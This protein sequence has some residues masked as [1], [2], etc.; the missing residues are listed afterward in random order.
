MDKLKKFILQICFFFIYS[1]AIYPE[2][3]KES[4]T[5]EILCFNNIANIL[6]QLNSNDIISGFQNI[7]EKNNLDNIVILNNNNPR[8]FDSINSIYKFFK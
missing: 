3:I 1:N 2:I 6:L 8:L 4:L 5:K 7:I